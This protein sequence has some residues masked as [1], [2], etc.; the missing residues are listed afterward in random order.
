VHINA[1]EIRISG[2]KICEQAGE[3]ET[4]RDNPHVAILDI[5]SRRW[6]RRFSRLRKKALNRSLA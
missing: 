5:A 2:R 6:R 4:Y 3:S 1:K